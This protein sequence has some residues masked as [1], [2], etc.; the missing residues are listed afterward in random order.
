MATIRLILDKRT[1][2]GVDQHPIK[3]YISHKSQHTTIGTGL[4]VTSKQFDGS[5]IYHAVKL[6]APNAL[7][8]NTAIADFCCSIQTRLVEW[9]KQGRLSSM[10]C[11][12]IRRG[13]AGDGKERVMFVAWLKSVA[14][15][16]SQA[17]RRIY[18]YT[19]AKMES[20]MG[21]ID[22]PFEA[23]DYAFCKR[24]DEWLQSSGISVNTRGLIF[25]YIRLAYNEAINLDRVA[26]SY[27][28][29]RRFKIPHAQKDKEYLRP[30]EF[31]R[32]LSYH[33]TCNSEQRAKD[34]FLL[35]FYLCGVNPKDL[36]LMAAPVQGRV[37]YIRSKTAY[38]N[39]TAVSIAL[40][41]QAQDIITRYRHGSL[42]VNWSEHYCSYDIFYHTVK[43]YLHRI[44]LKIGVPALTLYWARYSWATYASMLGVDEAV[45]GKALGHAASSLAGRVY[46]TFDWHRVD[47]ANRQVI[48]FT[49][50]IMTEHPSTT[51]PIQ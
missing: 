26:V 39:C 13:I 25:R 4:Y 21:H 16:K 1:T 3:V 5:D 18:D 7:Q 17:S 24:F 48:Q 40:Q 20:F 10:T 6:K 30:E 2:I 35:S 38:K 46:I 44:A 28:P 19:I 49:Q 34:V 45:I 29:F 41:P 47:E 51:A 11:P 50:K 43:H 42:L 31:A 32:L 15:A 22:L 23:I 12:D 27:Y 8:L 37:R 33:P 9:Q 36:Y 14:A